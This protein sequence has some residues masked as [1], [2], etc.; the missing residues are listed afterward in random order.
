MDECDFENGVEGC[1][2]EELKRKSHF[3]YALHKQVR[4]AMAVAV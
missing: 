3:L 4:S 2:R 1:F